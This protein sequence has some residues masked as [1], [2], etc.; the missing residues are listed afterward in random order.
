MMVVL[1][2]RK[3]KSK[4]CYLIVAPDKTNYYRVF[5][6]ALH[7]IYGSD[8]NVFTVR[9][10]QYRREEGDLRLVPELS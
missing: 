8:F 2:P 5:F 3:E 1:S 6:P 9:W 10:T 4:S 7:P